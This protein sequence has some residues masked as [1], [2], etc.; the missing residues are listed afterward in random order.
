MSEKNAL[1]FI[2]QVREG[3]LK[4]PPIDPYRDTLPDL[5]KQGEQHGL[6]FTVE[7][8]RMAY[9]RH[10]ATQWINAKPSEK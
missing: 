3:N 5:V 10:W 7:E 6:T 2:H 1:T 9:K 4:I 8:L